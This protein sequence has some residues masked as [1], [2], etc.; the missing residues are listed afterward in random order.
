MMKICK[1]TFVRQATQPTYIRAV[2]TLRKPTPCIQT[3]N[4]TQKVHRTVKRRKIMRIW[5]P[6]KNCY[7]EVHLIHFLGQEKQQDYDIKEQKMSAERLQKGKQHEL[8]EQK[9]LGR[10]SKDLM[11]NMVFSTTEIQ[12][13][14]YLL[15]YFLVQWPA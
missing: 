5:K 2:P 13:S 15:S 12:G 10:Y 4:V 7:I 1:Y 9:T 6:K 14:L 3:L 11:C 8:K